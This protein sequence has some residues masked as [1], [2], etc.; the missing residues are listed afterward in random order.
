MRRLA[1]AITFLSPLALAPHLLFYY[2]VTPKIVILFAG[3]AAALILAAFHLDSLRAFCGTKG[4][5]AFFGAALGLLIATAISAAM[6]VHPA[7]AWNGSNWRRFGVLTQAAC[8]LTGVIVAA[9]TRG[10]EGRIVPILRAISWAGIL[11]ALYGIL[12]YFGWDP[13]LDSSA[14]RAGEGLF[15]IVRPPGPMGHSDYFAAFLLW[16]VFLGLALARLESRW[17]GRA[18]A[19]LGAIAILLT[20]SRGALAGVVIGAVIYVCLTKPNPRVWGSVAALGAVALGLFFISPAGQ[21]LRARAHWISEDPAGG[22]RLLLWHDSI[23][24]AATHLWTGF[25]QDNFVAAFPRFQSVELAQAYPDFY[26]ESPHNIW[27]DT[28]S[29]Q[30]MVGLAA[31]LAMILLALWAGVRALKTKPEVASGLMAGL[32]AVVAAHQFAVLTAVNAFYL[33]LGCAVLI[34]LMDGGLDR[35]VTVAAPKLG[36]KAIVLAGGTAVAFV[37][38][39]VAGRLAWTDHALASAEH[40][41]ATGNVAD[42]AAAYHRAVDFRNTGLTADLYFSRRFARAA[43]DSRDALSKIYLSQ[44]AAGSASLA[45][46]VPEGRPNAWFNLAELGAS[47]SDT[48]AVETALRT[49]ITESPNWFKPHWVL[50]RLLF[51]E[52]RNEAAWQESQRAMQL[53]QKDPEVSSTLAPILSFRGDPSHSPTP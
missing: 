22:A 23:R 43:A 16:P 41:I 39:V 1:V 46:E 45:T 25:G 17:V 26:H 20:G 36:T 28:L 49:A 50:A 29:G 31:Q 24:M 14:Y 6:A 32:V 44:L 2:D 51:L 4:G 40:S 13:I 35:S 37:F 9:W 52:G 3:A 48:A 11:A 15:T 8:L 34:S 19:L 47:Q 7:L 38:L 30:G 42:A 10:E 33:Y 21:L 53:N 5:M 18:S 27:L 12:Q